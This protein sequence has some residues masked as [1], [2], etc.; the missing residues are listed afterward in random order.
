MYFVVYFILGREVM[1]SEVCSDPKDLTV[2]QQQQKYNFLTEH[3]IGPEKKKKIII[4]YI[5]HRTNK[6]S[7]VNMICFVCCISEKL[8]TRYYPWLK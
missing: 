8:V 3:K 1:L 5:K 6:C 7:W 4:T 2:A